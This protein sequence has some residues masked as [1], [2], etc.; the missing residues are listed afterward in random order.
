MFEHYCSK[1]AK[2]HSEFKDIDYFSECTDGLLLEYVI[3]KCDICGTEY[4]VLLNDYE[5]I[6]E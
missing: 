5:K 3:L 6:E 1:C 4:E 2:Y